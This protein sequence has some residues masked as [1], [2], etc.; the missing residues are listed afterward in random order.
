MDLTT[1][2]RV[3]KQLTL[4]LGL[5]NLTDARTWRYGSVRGVSV[6]S[7]SEQQRRT[8]P[9]LNASLSARLTF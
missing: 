3:S 8:E 4:R 2:W 9:G 5:H 7:V 6:A 1:W